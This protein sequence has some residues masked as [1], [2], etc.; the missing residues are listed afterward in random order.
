GRGAR[1][2]ALRE[3]RRL[4]QGREL[5]QLDLDDPGADVVRG[6]GE[7]ALAQDD[8]PVL[9]L[10]VEHVGLDL[11]EE[12]LG[13]ALEDR[14]LAQLLDRK[15]LLGPLERVGEGA[16]ELSFGDGHEVSSWAPAAAA[17]PA[18]G[19]SWASASAPESA[20]R[21]WPRGRRRSGAGSA[22][23]SA[24]GGE[25]AAWEEAARARRMRARREA[26]GQRGR[27]GRRPAAARWSEPAS[28]SGSPGSR[29]RPEESRPGRA[30]G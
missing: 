2:A 15:G 16:G 8:L 28:G 23:A 25:S 10:R 11:L 1:T 27:P 22:C 29:S 6:V 5:G 13:E 21:R 26:P 4:L 9:V 19:A 12:G 30:R 3:R 24:S 18:P 17:A 20:A 7:V 14:D